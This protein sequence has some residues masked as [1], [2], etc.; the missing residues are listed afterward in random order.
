MAKSGT[1]KTVTGRHILRTLYSLSSTVSFED[2][3]SDELPTRTFQNSGKRDLLSV[4]KHVIINGYIDNVVAQF[5]Q[6]VLVCSGGFRGGLGGS[7]LGRRTD[8]N[9]V[10]YFR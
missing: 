5:L 3:L 7:P 10:R 9:T 8:A 4:N 2:K 6:N 1:W